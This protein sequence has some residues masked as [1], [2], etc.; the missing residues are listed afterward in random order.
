MYRTYSN[1]QNIVVRRMVLWFLTS[2]FLLLL[3]LK[4]GSYLLLEP[5]QPSFTLLGTAQIITASLLPAP[6]F[7][8]CSSGR[9]TFSPPPTL[10]G[11]K[12]E[13]ILIWPIGRVHLIES[14]DWFRW[15]MTHD[16]PRRL[17]SRTL[18]ELLRKR[19]FF[20]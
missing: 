8:L 12:D 10:I 17:S 9:L 14:Y 5:A 3:T 7:S 13:G 18:L 11:S 19:S 20:H 15:Q 2:P 1:T 4:R 6:I 16:R